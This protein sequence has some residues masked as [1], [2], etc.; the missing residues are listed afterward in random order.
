MIG[1][2]FNKTKHKRVLYIPKNLIVFGDD[3]ELGSYYINYYPN[4]IKEYDLIWSSGDTFEKRKIFGDAI[5]YL[6][7]D[8]EEGLIKKFQNFCWEGSFLDI[9]N[10]HICAGEMFETAKKEAEMYYNTKQ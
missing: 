10:A 5:N 7:L 6:E 3:R 4:N 2:Y 9:I 1:Y 8:I